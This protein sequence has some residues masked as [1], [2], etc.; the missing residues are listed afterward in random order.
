M[1]EIDFAVNYEFATDSST[2]FIVI[3]LPTELSVDNL[4]RINSY[5]FRECEQI[6]F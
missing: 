2:L 5:D 4:S 3:I 1:N 6:N